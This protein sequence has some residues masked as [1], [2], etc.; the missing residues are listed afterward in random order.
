[1]RRIAPFVC[2]R[3]GRERWRRLARM[4]RKTG[5]ADRAM[6]SRRGAAT[7]RLHNGWMID[8]LLKL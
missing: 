4:F 8:A 6:D 7:G 3:R 2:C 5:G 1:M